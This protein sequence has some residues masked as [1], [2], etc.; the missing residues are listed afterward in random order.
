MGHHD[1]PAAHA[2]QAPPVL[3]GGADDEY[4]YTPEGSSYEH[5]DANVWVIAKFGVWL[6]IT[7]VI[8]HVGIWV[9]WATLVKQAEVT[10]EP[11]YPLATQPQLPPE[12]RLQQFPAN[13]ID[14]FRRSEDTRLNSYGYVN[15]DAGVVHIPIADAMRLTV[16]RGLPSRTGDASPSAHPGEMASDAS[17]G[18]VMERRRQ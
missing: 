5:T 4:A 11:Q 9:L 3:H 10:R 17:A 16:E 14:D 6:A 15:K 7:A 2:P 12:P 13:E 8:V 18:R 1:H